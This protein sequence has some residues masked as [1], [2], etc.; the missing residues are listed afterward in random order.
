MGKNFPISSLETILL[1]DTRKYNSV[2]VH[3]SLCNTAIRKK[4]KVAR[5]A[6]KDLDYFLSPLKKP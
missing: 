2:D 3:K 1:Q 4:Q 6:K 5:P